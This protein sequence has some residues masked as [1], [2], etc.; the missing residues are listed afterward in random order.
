MADGRMLKKTISNSKKLAL[1]SD[2]S[3]VVWFMLLPHT[4][5]E[6]RVHACPDIVKGQYLTLLGYPTKAIQKSLVE[7]HEAGLIVLYAVGGDQYAEFTRFKDFQFL[8]PNRER[9]STIPAPSCG[10]PP[11]SS[12]VTPESSCLKLSKVKLREDN[13]PPFIIPPPTGGSDEGIQRVFN[14]WNSQ[15]ERGRWKTHV[16]LT[17]DIRATVTDNL[18]RWP[19]EEICQAIT[20]FAMI[21]HGKEFLWTYDRWG[22]REFLGRHEKDDRKTLQ[23]LRFH[24]NNFREDD[25]LTIQARQARIQKQREQEQRQREAEKFIDDHRQYI[26]EA[27]SVV[28][29]DRCKRDPRMAYAAKKLRPEIF[30]LEKPEC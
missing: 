9:K 7:L 3:K 5:I 26:M 30:N 13:N 4:D 29:L 22:L 18:K 19:V 23:W 21:L 8:Q 14:H 17:P 12:G 25:W 15:Q 11:E 24:P 1:V 16:K 2:R 20:N 28:L 27:G 6:G 10:S